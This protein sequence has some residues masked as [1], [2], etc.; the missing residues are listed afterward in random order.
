MKYIWKAHHLINV[1]IKVTTLY[2]TNLT[3]PHEDVGENGDVA[4]EFLTSAL[5]GGDLSALQPS[6]FSRVTH[7]IGGWVGPRA[8]LHAVQ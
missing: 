3:P 1:N 6:R 7:W 8:E 2:F 5:N 4:P